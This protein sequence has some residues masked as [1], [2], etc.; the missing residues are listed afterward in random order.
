MAR[1]ADVSRKAGAQH[2][3]AGR[4]TWHPTGALSGFQTGV[5]EVVRLLRACES[6]VAEVARL[7]VFRP[8]LERWRVPAWFTSSE[9]LGTLASS[10]TRQ[11]GT[12]ASSATQRQLGT[13]T[14][15]ATQCSPTQWHTARAVG[16][17]FD[18]L[19]SKG[20]CN[21]CTCCTQKP[22]ISAELTLN[23]RKS[24]EF[25]VI[26]AANCASKF[27]TL[28]VLCSEMERSAWAET[29]PLA[30][31]RNFNWQFRPENAWLS[32]ATFAGDGG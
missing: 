21:Y 9:E 18:A 7:Q 12:L 1:F 31:I 26:G 19:P 8:E 4:G 5:A 16:L 11:L 10:A 6:F 14:S 15:S 2:A 28:S 25:R 13:R 24:G 22:G 20:G 23:S 3:H 29:R 30:N 27:S 17:P 32:V